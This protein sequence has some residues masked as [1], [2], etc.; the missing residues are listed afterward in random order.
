MGKYL[1]YGQKLTNVPVQNRMNSN[2]K[3]NQTKEK[4][5]KKSLWESDIWKQSQESV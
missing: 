1:T 3:I 5:T 4:K 2:L